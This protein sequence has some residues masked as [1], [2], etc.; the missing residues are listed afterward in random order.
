MEALLKIHKKKPIEV[1]LPGNKILNVF[2][3][4]Y[5]PDP[6]GEVCPTI[7]CFYYESE[8]L[9]YLSSRIIK[10]YIHRHLRTHLKLFSI[11][12]PILSNIEIR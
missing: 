4:D 1:P 9:N 3:Q 12:E 10:S 2:V 6:T 5:K 7:K 8:K 11:D